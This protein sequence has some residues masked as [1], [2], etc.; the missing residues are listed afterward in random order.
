[1]I[2][3]RTSL[4]RLQDANRELTSAQTLFQKLNHQL[5]RF[6]SDHVGTLTAEE[7]AERESLLALQ[8]EALSDLKDKEAIQRFAHHEI[9]AQSK[10]W[11]RGVELWRK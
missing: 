2:D 4:E 1:M 3:E 9:Y 8:Q 7:A 11:G 6:D 5:K 10:G